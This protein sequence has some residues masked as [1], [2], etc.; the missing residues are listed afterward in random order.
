MIIAD[1]AQD[2]AREIILV[3]NDN[4]R[5][6]NISNEFKYIVK[7]HFSRDAVW[8]RIKDDFCNY[9]LNQ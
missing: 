8:N 1:T 5:L 9:E 3:Y 6:K 7:K 2:F 4:E